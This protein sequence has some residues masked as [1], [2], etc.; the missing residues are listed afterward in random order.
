MLRQ[1]EIVEEEMAGRSPIPAAEQL[2]QEIELAIKSLWE[3][4]TVYVPE[5]PEWPGKRT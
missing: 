3:Q 2:L 4:T 1:K 5:R